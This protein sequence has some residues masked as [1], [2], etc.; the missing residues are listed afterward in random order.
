MITPNIAPRRIMRPATMGLF[1]AAKSSIRRVENTTNAISKAPSVTK[2]QKFGM[3]YVQFFGSKKNSKILKKSLKSIRD[4]LV[5]TFKIAKLLRSEVSKN[6]KLIGE[7]TKGK[8]GFFGLGLGGILGI[9]NLLTN[10]IILGALGIGAG[11]L[12]GKFLFDFLKNNRGQIIEFILSKTKG[13]YNTLQGLIVRI[14]RDFFGDRFK[15]PETRN[16]EIESENRIEKEMDEILEKDEKA[17]KRQFITEAEARKTATDNELQRLE[18]RRDVLKDI[19][20]SSKEDEE[21]DATEVRIEQLKTGKNIFDK[22]VKGFQKRIKNFFEKEFQR[23]PVFLRDNEDYLGLSR[24]EKF[25]KIKGLVGNFRSKGNSMDRIAEI[26]TRAMKSG[27]LSESQMAQAVDIMNYAERDDAATRAERKKNKQDPNITP[28]NFSFSTDLEAGA[29]SDGSGLDGN[30]FDVGGGDYRHLDQIKRMY[31]DPRGKQKYGGKMMRN[32]GNIM[33]DLDLASNSVSGKSKLTQ[34]PVQA[35]SS[36]TC[37]F[38][39]NL[40]IDNDLPGFNRS[41]LCITN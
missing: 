28:D 6:V 7:K 3:N 40:D 16:L 2:E 31:K 38:H 15:D 23:E 5:A 35:S 10:P 19:N 11:I 25:K 32:V 30:Y 4:S 9:I 13:L 18:N 36:P 20:R 1:S 22:D 24:E 8:R 29:F 33:S 39:S 12:G 14:L 41:L 26:Y 34:V 27:E 17:E 21:L 37:P